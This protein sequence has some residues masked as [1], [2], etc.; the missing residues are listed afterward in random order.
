MLWRI[1]R[2]NG[3]GTIRLIANKS[4]GTSAFG[5]KQNEEKKVGYTYD[6]EVACTNKNLC[7][8]NIDTDS[9]IKTYLDNWYNKNLNNYN[10]LIATTTYFN[11]TSIVSTD[12]N[13][14]Y[15]GSYD[16]LV[17]NKKPQFKC[18]NTTETYG[19]TYNLKVGLLS[20][21][22]VAFAGG[23]SE[24][25]NSNYYLNRTKYYWLSSPYNYNNYAG[26]HCVNDNGSIGH[27][28]VHSTVADEVVPVIN[29]K[30][31]I[32]YNFGNGEKSS[33]YVLSY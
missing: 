14:K 8:T 22:E 15:Y 16:R 2:I 21:D 18:P 26:G 29:L 33:P 1:V 7:D 24:S 30:K 19:G 13:N 5:N 6:N 9:T 28:G 31:D 25:N 20:A 11:D 3:D 17:T 32:I 12:G 27:A 10:K 4:I 23:V